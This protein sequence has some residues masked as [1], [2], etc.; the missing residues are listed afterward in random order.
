MVGL[1]GLIFETFTGE[2]M[3][4]QELQGEAISLG[5]T[6]LGALILWLMSARAKL[7]W[8]THSH[9]VHRVR[10]PDAEIA[11]STKTVTIV[12]PGRCSA[13]DVELVLNWPVET[14]HIWPQRAYR[15]EVNPEGRLSVTFEALAPKENLAIH[16]F[17][18][19]DSPE[20]VNVRSR[21]AIGKRVNI[22]PMRVYP[23]WFNYSCLLLLF[24]GIASIIYALGRM[25]G[26]FG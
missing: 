12:N 2:T 4:W 11:V 26:A 19:G 18:E 9:V 20:V 6:L 25:L 3:L 13:H 21:D 7:I 1:H 16:L 15:K 5:F 17:S 24:L 8:G 22:L 10:T 23:I 14:V